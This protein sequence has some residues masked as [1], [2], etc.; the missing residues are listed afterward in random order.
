M[1]SLGTVRK[2]DRKM[3]FKRFVEAM[4]YEGIYRSQ[5]RENDRAAKREI[6]RKAGSWAV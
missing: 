3:D 1:R 2:I 4:D 6:G 5:K